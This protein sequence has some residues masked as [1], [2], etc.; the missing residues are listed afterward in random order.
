V[1]GAA[2]A[3]AVFPAALPNNGRWQAGG[4]ANAAA[5]AAGCA[6]ALSSR[7]PSH[8]PCAPAR[9][10][11]PKVALTAP[12]VAP[13][14][15]TFRLTRELEKYGAAAAALAGR[16]AIVYGVEGTKLQAAEVT[17]M[18]LD[19]VLNMRSARGAEALS[20]GACGRAGAW[21]ADA[22]A[23][24]GV[25]SA[26]ARRHGLRR[27]VRLALPPTHC[28]IAPL[29]R[30]L[31]APRLN[32]WEINDMLPHVQADMERAYAQPTVLATELLHRCGRE[33]GPDMCSGAAGAGARRRARARANG[34]C[35]LRPSRSRGAPR[36]AAALAPR[37]RRRAAFSGGLARPL[38]PEPET[39]ESL[40]PEAVHAF[41]A[42]NFTAANMSLAAAGASLSAVNNAAAPLLAAG[43]RAAGGGGPAASKY[44]GGV[45]AALA[46]SSVPVV[47]LAYQAPG[48]LADAKATALTAVIKAL[49]NETREVMPYMHK[50]PAGALGSVLPLVHVST[51]SGPPVGGAARGGARGLGHRA[52][53]GWW[54]IHAGGARCRRPASQACCHHLLLLWP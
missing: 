9:T 27:G 12:A 45:L 11:P 54:H 17:E 1:A 53:L 52:L 42:E 10:R 16:E 36:L 46:P 29:C 39:L 49:L 30:P 43:K 41:V 28:R 50:E 2:A 20:M 35:C 40:T 6:R 7:A 38:L 23:P 13:R 18:L 34:P 8:G 44:T 14:R 26:P 19:S 21:G 5:G 22:G 47:A 32:Y 25:G 4:R 15:S 31:F 37:N 24:A 3:A 48:G 51:W 33:P